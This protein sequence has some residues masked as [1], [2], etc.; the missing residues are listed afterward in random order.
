[1]CTLHH[2]TYSCVTIVYQQ[3]ITE[4][5]VPVILEG[6]SPIGSQNIFSVRVHFTEPYHQPVEPHI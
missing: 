6:S 2:N 4:K 5:G 1:M 3:K